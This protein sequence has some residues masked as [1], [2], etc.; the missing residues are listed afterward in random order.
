M[1]RRGASASSQKT[2]TPQRVC[3]G[4]TIFQRLT[5][6]GL[7][8][9]EDNIRLVGNGETVLLSRAHDERVIA[10]KDLQIMN[11][12]VIGL[13]ERLVGDDLGI[14]PLALEVVLDDGAAVA[15]LT[16]GE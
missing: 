13:V 9:G 15:F 4:V 8:L 1:R 3:C 10:L 14:A 6:P 7:F 12:A 2:V 11:L 16:Q 5:K